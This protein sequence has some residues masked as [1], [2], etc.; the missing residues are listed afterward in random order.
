[1]QHHDRIAPSRAD[2]VPALVFEDGAFDRD[3]V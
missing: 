3:R 2:R 1:M